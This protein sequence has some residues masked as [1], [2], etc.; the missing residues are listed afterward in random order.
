M[1]SFL[2]AHGSCVFLSWPKLA[3]RRVFSS[4]MGLRDLALTLLRDVVSQSAAGNELAR[5]GGGVQRICQQL[6]LAAA[7]SPAA[8]QAAETGDSSGNNDDDDSSE[9]PNETQ[10][11]RTGECSG[12][13]AECTMAEAR[14][15]IAVDANATEVDLLKCA[16]QS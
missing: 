12:E 13:T 9:I 15:F 6:V 5:V 11:A 3:F 8:A 14:I 7:T 16:E 4:Q 2:A 10:S 1:L